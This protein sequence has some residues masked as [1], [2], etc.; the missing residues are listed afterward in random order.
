L[1]SFEF[2][3]YVKEWGACS[4]ENTNVKVYHFAREKE[5]T[6][7][8]DSVFQYGITEANLVIKNQFIIVPDDLL[9]LATIKLWIIS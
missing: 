7:F 2:A 4:F 8:M 6:A 3:P 5:L 1:K 9:K